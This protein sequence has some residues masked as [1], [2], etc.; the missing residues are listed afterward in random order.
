MTFTV[1]IVNCLFIAFTLLAPPIM[2][3][4]WVSLYLVVAGVLVAYGAFLVIRALFFEQTG[5][6]FLLGSVMM[7]VI[8]FGYDIISYQASFDYSFLFLNLGYVI[9]FLLTAVALL[10]HLNIFTDKG[11]KSNVLKYSDMFGRDQ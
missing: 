5:V 4:K 8:T 6:L 10:Y 7:G 3:T 11:G 9:M 1:I 2:F